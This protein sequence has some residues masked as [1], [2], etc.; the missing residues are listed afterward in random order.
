MDIQK[1]L[2]K[3]TAWLDGNG[4]RCEADLRRTETGRGALATM[5]YL[6][7]KIRQ[8]E[9]ARAALRES[10]KMF[11]LNDETG[12]AEICDMFADLLERDSI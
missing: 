9:G 1:I 5:R 10:A 6:R 2:E 4:C 11:R 7:H 12:H 3:H 8:A